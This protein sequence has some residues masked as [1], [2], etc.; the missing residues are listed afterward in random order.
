MGLLQT[1]LAAVMLAAQALR[2]RQPRFHP[3]AHQA[4]VCQRSSSQSAAA[5][6][7][8][9]KVR[10]VLYLASQGSKFA[11]C[12]SVQIHFCRL[13]A[14]QAQ[15]LQLHRVT[16]IR[17]TRSA[18][19]LKKAMSVSP[20]IY[21]CLFLIPFH[22]LFFPMYPGAGSRPLLT[23]PLSFSLWLSFAR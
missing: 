16:P 21:G 20:R 11:S 15:V 1:P 5:P 23:C 10:A 2:R 9:Y 8:L 7:C 18:V 12:Q 3:Y 4:A 13:S 17:P 22:P 6:R 19:F 14:L